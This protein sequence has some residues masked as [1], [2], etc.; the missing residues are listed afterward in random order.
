M[1]FWAIGPFAD[2][3]AGEEGDG[4]ND[5]GHAGDFS[6]FEVLAEEEDA[7]QDGDDGVDVGV[8]GD[9][10]D[11]D[12]LQEVDVA[13]VADEGAAGDEPGLAPSAGRFQWAWGQRPRMVAMRVLKMPAK[14]IC[15]A[16]ATKLLTG[17]RLRRE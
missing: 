10:G 17:S 14:I 6:G 13:G 1:C 12:V 16:A 11:G 5:G 4:E 8:G 15:Q 3:G 2:L 9:L 7:E